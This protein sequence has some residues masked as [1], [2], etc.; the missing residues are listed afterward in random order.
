MRAK[1]LLGKN[2]INQQESTFLGKL[3]DMN[4]LHLFDSKFRSKFY[5]RKGNSKKTEL[6]LNQMELLDH[7]SFLL[8]V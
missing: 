7:L 4:K 2:R 6:C 5:L 8:V 3:V 1:I